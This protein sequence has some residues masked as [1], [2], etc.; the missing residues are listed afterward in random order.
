ML[1]VM[2]EDEARGLRESGNQH[3]AQQQAWPIGLS[4]L[5]A[6]SRILQGPS[7]SQST[8]TAVWLAVE[9]L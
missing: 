9:V 1:D 8:C 6:T 5:G 7:I 2:P 4:V 3:F